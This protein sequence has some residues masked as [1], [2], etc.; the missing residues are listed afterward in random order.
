M[1]RSDCRKAQFLPE[2]VI[3]EARLAVFPPVKKSGVV[4]PV[5]GAEGLEKLPE[6]FTVRYDRGERLSRNV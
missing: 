2:T 5:M 1:K 6:S 4:S 3:Q